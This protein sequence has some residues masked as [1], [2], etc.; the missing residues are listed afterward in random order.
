MIHFEAMIEGESSRN[1]LYTL[2]GTTTRFCHLHLTPVAFVLLDDPSIFAQ[3]LDEFL[4]T[5]AA[6]QILA[7]GFP[8]RYFL[9]PRHV[10]NQS[11]AIMQDSDL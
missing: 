9:D 3:Q 4:V 7:K 8:V 5:F 6:L 10:P 2:R 11:L 1:I